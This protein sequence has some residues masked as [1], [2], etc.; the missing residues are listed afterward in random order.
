MSTARGFIKGVG[1][2]QFTGTFIVD[3]VDQYHFAG[4]INP[5]I[6]GLS[7]MQAEVT[8]PNKNQ[9]NGQHEFEGQVGTKDMTLRFSN[10]VI[11]T[12]NLDSPISSASTV[13]GMGTWST[14]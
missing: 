9:L 6:Q 11:I 13:S 14:T 12:G 4:E 8:Y 7:S 5:P 10:G 1:G 3:N 2:S